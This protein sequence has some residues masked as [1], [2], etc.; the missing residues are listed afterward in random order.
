MNQQHMNMAGMNAAGGPVGGAPMMAN[1]PA[2]MTPQDNKL[3]L[4]TYIYD[5]FLKNHHYDLARAI[6]SSDI[7]INSKQESPNR[8]D[9]NGVADGMD[10]DNKDD[11]DKRPLDLPAASIPDSANSAENSFLLDWWGQF[12]DVFSAHRNKPVKQGSGAVQYLQHQRVCFAKPHDDMSE[13]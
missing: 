5:Y 1:G 13:C 11:V 3:L 7:P 6:I 9:V 4:N 2:V 10:A 12:W 8:R